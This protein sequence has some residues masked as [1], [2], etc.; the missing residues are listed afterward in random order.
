MFGVSVCQVVLYHSSF[1]RD[2]RL[3]K[4]SVSDFLIRFL[5]RG[6]DENTE[7]FYI[8][9]RCPIWMII[10]STSTVLASLTSSIPFA[11]SEHFGIY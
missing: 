9:V 10:T 6:V 1:P 2:S 3:L 7:G 5:E 4:F 11:G 8:I